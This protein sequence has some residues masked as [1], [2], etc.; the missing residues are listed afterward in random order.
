MKPKVVASIEPTVN[1][2]PAVFISLKVSVEPKVSH[3][4]SEH[5]S[6]WDE[7]EADCAKQKEADDRG[8]GEAD[9]GMRGGAENGQSPSYEKC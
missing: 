9:D 8:Q 4:R 2:T 7:I 6:Y 3:K 5:E 1:L